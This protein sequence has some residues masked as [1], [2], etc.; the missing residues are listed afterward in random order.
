MLP[1][2]AMAGARSSGGGTLAKEGLCIQDA[3]CQDVLTAHPGVHCR[4]KPRAVHGARS[5]SCLL[6]PSCHSLSLPLSV[7]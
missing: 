1:E 5:A 7:N 3:H 2:R 4:L 6:W